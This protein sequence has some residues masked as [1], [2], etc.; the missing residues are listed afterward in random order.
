MGFI[1]NDT[2]VGWEDRSL[3]IVLGGA[4]DSEVGEQKVMVNHQDLS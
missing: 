1:Q 2:S 3:L 4:P